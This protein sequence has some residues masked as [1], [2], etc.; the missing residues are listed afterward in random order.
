MKNWLKKKLGHRYDTKYTWGEFSWHPH[1]KAL[2]F[3]LKFTSAYSCDNDLLIIQP[4]ICSFYIHMPTK[5]CMDKNK[6]NGK[7]KTYGFYIYPNMGKMEALVLYWGT[8]RKH[9]EMPWTYN[10]GSTEILDHDFNTVYYEDRKINKRIRFTARMDVED[11]IK[12]KYAE[13]YDF[14]Y[15]L[16]NGKIQERLAKVNVERRVWAMRW[17]PFL[18]ISQTSIWCQ[19]DNEVG[20]R[21][22][23]WKGG[24]TGCGY[25]ILPGETPEQTFRRM[26]RE[27][28]FT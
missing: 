21:T 26:E 9:I 24:C 2:S 8:W 27:R 7:E 17:L 5:M 12:S 18:K 20:E 10:W 3:S 16:K 11:F 19:F 28:K 22:G 15:T 25:N 23:S 4:F 1:I 6:S 13:I 14:T